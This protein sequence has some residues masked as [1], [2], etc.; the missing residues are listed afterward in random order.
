MCK[1]GG[2]SVKRH[3]VLSNCRGFLGSLTARGGYLSIEERNK[4]A[5]IKLAIQHSNRSGSVK[6][7]FSGVKKLL[8]AS[9]IPG[10]TRNV[11][12]GMMFDSSNE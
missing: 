5:K 11:C 4:M 9:Q 10:L 6:N 12:K 7:K 8:K 1:F 3:M 2:A